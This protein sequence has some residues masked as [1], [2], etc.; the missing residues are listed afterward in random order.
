M[1]IIPGLAAKA[2]PVVGQAV[3]IAIE[4]AAVAGT[5]PVG[6]MRVHEM[7]SH[8]GQHASKIKELASQYE[9]IG[10]TAEIPGGGFG[11]A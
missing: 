3:S 10:S 11:P 9:S 8:S 5:V 4:V 6:T 7:A 1:S 2:I